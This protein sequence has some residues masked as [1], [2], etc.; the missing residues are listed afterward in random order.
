MSHGL[1]VFV[2]VAVFIYWQVCI[3]LCSTVVC[4]FWFVCVR[5]CSCVQA[6]IFV[7]LCHYFCLRLCPLT[8]LSE[9]VSP[10]LCPCIFASLSA[11]IYLCPC[12]FLCTLSNCL[13][14]CASLLTSCPDSIF[15]YVFRSLS[16]SLS[17]YLSHD[18]SGRNY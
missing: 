17:F 2:F 1:S 9:L 3:H 18:S 13:F 8:K 4:V 14:A 16:F 15:L 5:L 6:Y 11:Y 10:Y 12:L 7:C